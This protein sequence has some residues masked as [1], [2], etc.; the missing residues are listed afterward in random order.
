M[1]RRLI[2]I[3]LLLPL[4][5][6]A[7]KNPRTVHAV[8]TSI[9]PV[10]DGRLAEPEWQHASPAADFTQIDPREGEP[11][12]RRTEVRVLFDDEAV[13]FACKM[14]DDEPSVITARLS[15]RDD[16]VESDNVSICLDTFHDLQTNFAFIVNAAGV[17][18]DLLQFNDGQN[19]DLSW[20]A[21]WD[22]QTV[23]TDD[24][25]IA[26]MKIPYQALRFPEQQEQE[27][28]FQV[29]REQ[30]GRKELN[31]WAFI[32]KRE[33]GWTSQF[34]RLL[35]IRDI[36]SVAHLEILPYAVGSVRLAPASPHIPTGKEWSA[37]A[38]VDVKYRP[39]AGLTIDATF[40]PDFG[41]VEADPAVLNLS[42]FE[43]FY[44]EKRPFFVE[45]TQIFQFNT[46]GTG[47]GMF[48]TRRIGRP[49]AVEP[50]PGGVILDEPRFATILGAA[51]ISGK[52]DN[53]LSIGV[54]EAVTGRGMARFRDSLGRE[55]E[56][57]VEPLANYSL[58]RLRK[59]VLENSNV[60]M[61][62]TAVNRDKR[63]PAYTAGSDF[64]FRLFENM[65][66]VD[67]F[68]ALT[69]ATPRDVLVTGSAGR[70]TM[71]KT[72]GEHWRWTV[73][74]DFT[75]PKYYVNDMGFFRRPNDYGMMPQLTYRDDVPGSWYRNW[76]VST[77]YHIRR[78]FDGA[79]LNDSYSLS[80]AIEWANY[81]ELAAKIEA[82]RGTYDDRETRGNG[83]FRKADLN[84]IELSLETD[85]RQN[86]VAE[87]EFEGARDSRNGTSLRVETF[88]EIRP[89]SNLTLTFTLEHA[90]RWRERAWVRN[91]SDPGAG[92]GLTSIVAE[93]T[94]R[95]WDLTT[96]GS[97]V[98]TR[99]LTLQAYVQ[100]FSAEGMYGAFARM[101]SPEDVVPY[102]HDE[103]PFNAL[104]LNSNVVLR[105]EFLPGS[106]AYLVWSQRREGD[107]E[108]FGV[109]PGE[110]IG[111]LFGL[112][113]ENVVTLKV[114]YWFSR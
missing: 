51:K 109:S 102:V 8:R 52:L 98:F 68:L 26:E 96:R 19:E 87:L 105:W 41:Q 71:S 56:E 114:S 104:A 17:K 15:R 83:L 37:N 108:R 65:Y 103:P 62:L 90:R 81:W 7:G 55:Y 28:G 79:E 72:G 86:V 54:V 1:A 88:L 48:Y 85:S 49:I 57:E 50:P 11:A 20:D 89:A 99:D 21:V 107:L 27:W 73:S 82:D 30:P 40:N 23:I 14:Y 66:R 74:G 35:G 38:G 22:V 2:S 101:V 69:S 46:F 16:L 112:P 76:S 45:G 97:F 31:F 9:P 34:G 53:G 3:L 64:T 100:L 80:G 24:G 70:L 29:V 75:S 25:W 42:T 6:I 43:T 13:Y 78:N 106:T 18:T 12:S 44:P 10:I 33:S 4:A 93:R 113:A 110:G 92:P 95:E 60:G 36:P 58:I 61:V 94:T 39:T 111:D 5:A 84:V 67:G 47:S 77:S 59:D 63:T 91:V 32:P